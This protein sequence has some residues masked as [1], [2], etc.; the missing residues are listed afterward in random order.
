MSKFFFGS[1]GRIRVSE[2]ILLDVEIIM[3]IYVRLSL[4]R[5]NT[6]KHKDKSTQ[7]P[8]IYTY[9]ART[10]RTDFKRLRLRLHS[11]SVQQIS[12]AIS[13]T[14]NPTKI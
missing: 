1:N 11:V 4:N 12:T 7:K 9:T 2:R 10:K 5:L 6:V 14:I 13:A 3:L 8:L